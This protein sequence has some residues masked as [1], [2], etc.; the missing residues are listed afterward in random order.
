MAMKWPPACASPTASLH[1]CQEVLQQDVGLECRAG[2][3]RDDEERVRQV[4]RVLDRGDL[5]GVGRV[6]H[7]Q[8]RKALDGAEGLSHHLRTQA[9][10]AHA[11]EHGVRDAG[12]GDLLG[13]LF[14]RTDVRHL[15]VGDAEPVQPV[16]FVAAGPERGVARPQPPRLAG[17]LPI[18]NDV[19]DLGGEIMREG[20]SAAGR[21]STSARLVVPY[22]RPRAGCRRP[23]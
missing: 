2:L 4:H 18:G 7:V 13:D 21:A 9:R 17:L 8:L 15:V 19:S 10:S 1:A 20:C 6:Q 5:C 12:V 16:A 3:A 23:R 11:E 14:Q 22:R